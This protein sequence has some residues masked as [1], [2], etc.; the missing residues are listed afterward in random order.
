MTIAYEA[1]R[2]TLGDF[3]RR[4]REGLSPEE[5]G[6]TALDRRRTPG[7]RRDEVAER[8]NMSVVYYERLERGRGPM[9]SPAMLGSIAKALRLNAEESDYMY[10]LVGQQAPIGDRRDEPA[11]PDLLAAMDAMAPTVI[12]TITDELATVLVQNA[13][14]TELLG[15]MAG[16]EGPGANMLWRWFTEPG[17]RDWMEPADNHDNTSRYMAAELRATLARR[18]EDAGALAFLRRLLAASDEFRRIW[19]D[20]DVAS[21]RC[22]YKRIEHPLVGPIELEVTMVLSPMSSQRLVV[23]QPRRDDRDSGARLVQLHA[24]LT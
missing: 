8:A 19:D 22:A 5:A 3:L 11:H 18:C 20:H 21:V 6:I 17:W 16:V 10:S 15:P 7:L 4:R 2:S 12:A 23:M 9:P 1:R 24:Q 13:M 14:S